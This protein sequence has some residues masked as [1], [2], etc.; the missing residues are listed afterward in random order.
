MKK[1]ADGL[2][3]PRSEVEGLFLSQEERG[4]CDDFYKEGVFIL[5][6]NDSI[7]DICQCAPTDEGRGQNVLESDLIGIDDGLER[8][9]DD[10]TDEV[11]FVLQCKNLLFREGG[12]DDVHSVVDIFQKKES[13]LTSFM[14]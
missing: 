1:D 10:A 8:D 2:S 6:S 12:F 3:A 13:R 5:M 7:V 4:V 14:V 11:F 9:G